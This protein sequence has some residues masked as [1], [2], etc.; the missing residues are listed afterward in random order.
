MREPPAEPDILSINQVIQL[1][2]VVSGVVAAGTLFYGSIGTP[3]QE[4]TWDGESPREKQRERRNRVLIGI[5]IPATLIS[6]G[7]QLALIFMLSN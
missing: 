4:K 5:G 1:V 6:F 3:E 7:C 2:A